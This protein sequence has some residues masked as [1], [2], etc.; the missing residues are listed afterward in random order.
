MPREVRWERMF[1]DQLEAAFAERPVCYMPYG[2]CEPHG[3]ACALGLDGL[4]VHAIACE[5]AHR[6]GGIVA[7]TDWWHIHETGGYATWAARYVGE[8]PRAWLTAMPPWQ[9]F[10]NVLYQIRALDAIGF[11][12]AILLTG[13]YGPNWEDLKTLCGLVQ[14]WVGARLYGLPDFEANTPGF[15]RDGRSGGDHAGKVETSLL[16]AV[17]PECVDLGRF[18]PEDAPGAHFAMGPNA[19]ESSA[20][21][22]ARMVE[23]EIAF[24]AAKA[25]ELLALWEREAPTA[26]LVSFADVERLW[27][28]IV[29][30]ALP[31]FRT[32]QA[33]WGESDQVPESSLWRPNW[34]FELPKGWLP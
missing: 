19:R 14:P 6:H 5:T 30:P 26:R 22:G 3:P 9:H 34:R 4:K 28:D 8:P 15:D 17:E 29:L 23:D 11:R 31:D 21:V 2:I 13:H 18:P 1:P 24:L 20:E 33:D 12:A 25:D 16:A 27:A 7:P 10:R 32:M